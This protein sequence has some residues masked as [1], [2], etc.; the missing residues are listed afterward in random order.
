[1]EDSKNWSAVGALTWMAVL[2]ALMLVLIALLV[3]YLSDPGGGLL[4]WG[5]SNTSGSGT[6][7]KSG[8][9]GALSIMFVAAA[10]ILILVVCTLTIVTKRLGLHDETEAMGLPRG[11]IRA[12]IALMLILL[13][14][15][16]AI[17]LFNSTRRVP[18]ADNEL[19]TLQGVDAA[20]LATIPT[21]DIRTQTTRTVGATT[22]YDLVLLPSALDNQASDDLAKQLIT[23]LGTLVT[24]VAAFYFGANSVGAALKG[25][26]L[27]YLGKE[28]PGDGTAGANPPKMP[29]TPQVQPGAPQPEPQ[30]EPQPGP[31]R[32]EPNPGSPPV[33]AARPEPVQREQPQPPRLPPTPPPPDPI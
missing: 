25:Q 12:I 8:P 27:I 23:V 13:F 17:F 14:F 24:A 3:V 7:G 32:V 21:E 22:V 20:R 15:I 19:R 5:R 16:A 33:E 1:V 11:S 30:P 4:P 26:A 2:T 9:E 10:V 31:P 6:A 29:N 18:P 28:P